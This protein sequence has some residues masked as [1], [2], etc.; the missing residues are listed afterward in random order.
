MSHR[1]TIIGA[2]ADAHAGVRKHLLSSAP[3]HHRLDDLGSLPV[4]TPSGAVLPLASM[5]RI[6]ETVDT[7]SIRRVDGQRMVTLSIIPPESV[8]LE[9]AV[10]LA[11]VQVVEHL[12]TTGAVPV[13]VGMTIS[14]A[15]DQLEATQKALA[16]N[17]VVALILVYLVMVAIFTHWG[18]PLLIMASVPI[19]VSGGI[20]AYK[21]VDLL[22]RLVKCGAQVRVIMTTSAARF[23]GPMTFEVLS[24]NQVCVDLFDEKD[25]AAIRHIAWAEDAHGVGSAAH[26]GKYPRGQPPFPFHE[27]LAGLLAHDGLKPGDHL[28][29]GMRPAGGAEHVVGRIHVSD[30]IAK[31]LVDGV[32]QDPRAVGYRHHRGSKLFHPENVGPL[33]LHILLAH[34]NCTVKAELGSHGCSCNPVLTSSSFCNNTCY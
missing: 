1:E 6:V 30:P 13:N 18:Y 31:G 16:G 22:R 4:Y 9:T 34:V 17:Y 8:P 3:S 10:D 11:R 33:S 29:E 15:S 21:S 32:F 19:G 26:T 5:A 27:L 24:E 14:G 25:D 23:I 20:A 12:R 2:V 28:R 7:S